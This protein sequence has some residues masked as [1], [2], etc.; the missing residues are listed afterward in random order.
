MPQQLSKF[1][2]DT[3]I[4]NIDIDD[5]KGYIM[6]RLLHLGDE[7]AL[8]WLKQTYTRSDLKNYVNRGQELSAKD[9]NFFNLVY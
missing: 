3:D 5:H 8:R 9:R 6:G 2:W 7:A 4:T 1:F